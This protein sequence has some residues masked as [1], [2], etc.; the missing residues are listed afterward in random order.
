[1]RRFAEQRWVHVAA[2]AEHQPVEVLQQPARPVVDLQHHGFGPGGRNGLDVVGD[3][4][5]AGDTNANH[6]YILVGTSMPIM[7]S[8][9]VSCRRTYAVAAARQALTSSRSSLRIGAR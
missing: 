4:M 5:T 9:R 2:A 3:A 1:M 7:S 8:A 6:D